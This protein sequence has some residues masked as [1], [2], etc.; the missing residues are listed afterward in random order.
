[1]SRN[2]KYIEQFDRSAGKPADFDSLFRFEKNE[3]IAKRKI[4]MTNNRSRFAVMCSAA[5]VIGIAVFAAMA[6]INTK[7]IESDS[8]MSKSTGNVSPELTEYIEENSPVQKLSELTDGFE[9]NITGDSTLASEILTNNIGV[10]EEDDV[11]VD[12][13]WILRFN[14][15]SKVYDSSEIKYTIKPL[16][17]Y[18]DDSFM[19]DMEASIDGTLVVSVPIY[20]TE[21]ELQIG[22]EYIMPLF[23][24]TH[25]VHTHNDDNI[26]HTDHLTDFF[27]ERTDN[28]WLIYDGGR[29]RSSLFDILEADTLTV[30]NDTGA[31]GKYYLEPSDEAMNEKLISYVNTSNYSYHYQDSDTAVSQISLS[32]IMP[33]AEFEK[34]RYGVT[35]SGETDKTLLIFDNE[36]YFSFMPNISGTVIF[37]GEIVNGELC[38]AVEFANYSESD[39]VSYCK[40]I[41]ISGLNE[42]FV[43][44][45]DILG[46]ESVIGACS[47]EPVYMQLID[48]SGMLM[49]TDISGYSPETISQ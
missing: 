47:S 23:V 46:K 13:Q 12:W 29:Y 27:A 43:S 26:H 9:Y 38:T 34:V 40:T 17:A 36:Q 7:G 2:K 15:V 4:K 16:E 39:D 41:L 21:R 22:R 10:I 6:Y 19:L 28:G 5:A 3:L 8:V 44:T 14:V 30:D 48:S 18:A 37:A 25:N 20:P 11:T 33:N 24:H 32:D 31:G 42:L 35:A 1:M 45:G 49:E